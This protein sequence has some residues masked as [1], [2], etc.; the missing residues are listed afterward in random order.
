VSAARWL[1]AASGAGGLV[2]LA[3][4]ARA[5]APPDQYVLFNSGSSV[6]QDARTKLIWQRYASTAPV[7]FK[8]P[9]GAGNDAFG[10]CAG[11]SLST[12][13]TGWRLPS[14]KELLTIVDEAP[15]T[16]YEG[17]SLVFKAIDPNAFPSTSA[18][19]PYWSSSMAPSSPGSAYAV[20]FHTGVS[21]TQDITTPA[22]VRCVHD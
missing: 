21:I 2:A 3:S 18:L 16:E 17:G 11:V 13:P 7:V 20:S 19:Y 4:F 12:F 1:R 22:Y 8:D 10:A 9:L 5:D 14:Y 15:H 6:I